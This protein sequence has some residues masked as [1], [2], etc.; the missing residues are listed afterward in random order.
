MIGG[1]SMDLSVL[2]G[3][4]PAGYRAEKKIQEF[5]SRAALLK[6]LTVE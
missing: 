6:V 1:F 4:D 3:E 5:K 2:E